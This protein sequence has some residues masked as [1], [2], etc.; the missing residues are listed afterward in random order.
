V[1]QSNTYIIIFSI[2]LT[3]ILGGLLSGASQILGPTQKKAQDLDTKKQILG[4]IPA[5]KEKIASMTA[6]EILARYAEV[7]H[8]EVADF[9]GNLVATNEKGEP[10]VAEN[11]N[12]EKNY[13]KPA[14]ER[15]YP[16]F[17][18]EN[19]GERA[20]VIPVFGAGLWDAI[21]GFV[22]LE[23]D[24]QT[25]KGVTF[26]HKGETP[27]LGARITTDEIQARYQGKSI[28]E[29]GELVSV[30]MIKGER[31]SPDKLGPSKVDG[32]AGATLTGNGVNSMLNNYFGYY[33]N[34]FNKHVKASPDAMTMNNQ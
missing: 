9:E 15:V 27:G 18:Y 28:F 31:N 19:N 29:D 24:T 3:A 34:Y 22:A 17:K 11:V 1:R 4:A 20:Y 13:K 6:E 23:E 12:I 10:M 32:M 5:E 21:W 33:Q 14:E 30:T 16:V 25:I 2:V 7:I 8:S 26:A